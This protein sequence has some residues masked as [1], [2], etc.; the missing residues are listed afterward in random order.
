MRA[1]NQNEFRTKI[2]LK[3]RYAMSARGEISNK[4]PAMTG[5]T[6]IKSIE[7]P[8]GTCKIPAKIENAQTSKTPFSH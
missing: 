7:K 3:I 6:P 5:G 8:T 1:N 2:L 4:R